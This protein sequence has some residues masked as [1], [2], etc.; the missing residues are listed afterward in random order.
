MLANLLIYVSQLPAC[1][2]NKYGQL[3]SLNTNSQVH[4]YSHYLGVRT[5]SPIESVPLTPA[6]E[7][8]LFAFLCEHPRPECEGLIQTKGV[9][10][11]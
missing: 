8:F 1:Y 9:M 4:R 3:Q 2:V 7:S 6:V 5:L 10:L 11:R